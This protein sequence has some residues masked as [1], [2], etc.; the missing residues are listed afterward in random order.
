MENGDVIIIGAGVSGLRAA[1]L[2]HAA[3]QRVRVLEAAPEIGGRVR[4]TRTGGFLLDHGFQV[5]Q[6]AY[7]EVSKALDLKGLRLGYFLPGACVWNGTRLLRIADPTRQPQYLAEALA[8]PL[9]TLADK[10][11]VARLKW[12][13]SRTAPARI[14][15]SPETGTGVFLRQNGFS[16][17]F[18]TAFFQ[19]FFRGIFLEE[20]L[21][22]SSRMFAFV[23]SMLSRGYA[24]L[25]ADG[26]GA[27]PAQLAAQLPPE[28]LW[29]ECPAREILPRGVR[30]ADGRML[31]ARHIVLA[32]NLSAA[33]QLTPLVQPRPWN[34]T[35]CW[36]LACPTNPFPAR[37]L[38][39]NGSEKGPI[40]NIAVPSSVSP[41]YAPASS[42]LITVSIRPNHS[43]AESDLFEEIRRWAN[44]PD[45]PLETL[46][47]DSI[48]EALPRQEPGDNSFGTASPRL[49]DGLW[50]CGDHRFSASLEGALASASL[51]TEAILKASA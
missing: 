12:R 35:T 2:L 24:A 14:Y 42:H 9:G 43:P 45:L 31:E 48:P 30:L 26:I 37:M 15:A 27:I 4:T 16:E 29:T 34:G 1:Q 36:H 13:L 23:F 6:T 39:L 51:A 32:T 40:S 41:S 7:P 38:V 11:R 49:A 21:A 18:I 17:G 25:P 8:S 5:L 50:V 44:Q 10:L 19:P 20:N 47:I 46:R 22:S 28:A 3:G 33:A